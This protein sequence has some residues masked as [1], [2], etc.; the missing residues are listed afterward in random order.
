[1]LN[2]KGYARCHLMQENS[3]KQQCIRMRVNKHDLRNASTSLHITRKSYVQ[4]SVSCLA[5]VGW[6]PLTDIDG[7]LTALGFAWRCTLMSG[8]GLRQSIQSLESTPPILSDI[9]QFR[10][11]V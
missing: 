11:P 1:M 3:S 10:C 9:L 8:D 6:N 2:A 5:R 4:I 7:R